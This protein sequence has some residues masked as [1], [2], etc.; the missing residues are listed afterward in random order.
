[1]SIQLY[2]QSECLSNKIFCPV[3]TGQPLS[4]PGVLVT[5]P[6]AR[7]AICL[8]GKEGPCTVDKGFC[9]LLLVSGSMKGQHQLAV[10]GLDFNWNTVERDI[11]TLLNP[12]VSKNFKGK[13]GPH[14]PLA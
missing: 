2:R 1:M 7:A 6:G 3:A 13:H 4:I 12:M 5:R 10:N 14:A 11:M 8:T 9:R